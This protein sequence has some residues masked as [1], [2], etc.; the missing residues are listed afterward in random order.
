MIS[1][2]YRLEAIT[3]R[4]EAI[5]IRSDAEVEAIHLFQAG[6]IAEEKHLLE[7]RLQ[8]PSHARQAQ[9]L[10]VIFGESPAKST[11]SCGE[12][13]GKGCRETREGSGASKIRLLRPAWRSM[14]AA[15]CLSGELTGG[16]TDRR[17]ERAVRPTNRG[18]G[19]VRRRRHFA[20][21]HSVEGTTAGGW[22]RH[23]GHENP[24]ERGPATS[25][26]EL[27]DEMS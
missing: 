11:K 24:A 8:L 3:L 23:G 20:H 6:W 27:S 26:V 12:G 22:E 16:R 15:R 18:E 10:G 13:C 5:A 9:I 1:C 14:P 2:G 7:K 4:L 21:L 17:D 19:A 25:P